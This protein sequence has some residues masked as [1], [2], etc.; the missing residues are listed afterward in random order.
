MSRIIGCRDLHIA[1][2]VQDTQGTALSIYKKPVRVPALISMKIKD[3][4]EQSKF[5]SDDSV[6][7]SFSKTSGKE[8]TVELGYLTNELEA[9]IT[10]KSVD[11]KG[12]LIQKG[13]NAPV[14]LALL[15]RAPKSKAGAFRYLCMYKG[16]LTR[17]ESE[18]NTQEDGVESSTVTL[19]GT[20]VPL[21]CNGQMAA[22][23]DSDD[24]LTKDSVDKWFTSVYGATTNP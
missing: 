19:T 5:F 23:A 11:A 17:T 14:E 21:L 2:L 15:F 8:V 22:I 18:Y 16:T 4:V 24:I 6:E 20:F 1:E 13:D 7:Q 9:L 3:A 12:V 10:G